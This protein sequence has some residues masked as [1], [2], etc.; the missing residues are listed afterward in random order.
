MPEKIAD[1]IAA[2]IE[3]TGRIERESEQAY[4]ALGRL[5]PLLS[6]EM[7]KSADI[8]ERS[9]ADIRSV[10]SNGSVAQGARRVDSGA[11][12]RSLHDRDSAFLGRINDSME[13]LGSLDEVIAR[14]RADSE[15]MEIISLNAMTA[16][17]KSGNEGR[18]FSVITDELKR[19]SGSTIALT[20]SVTGIGRSLLESFTRLRSGLA[21]LDAFR[22]DYFASLDETVT[23]GFGEIERDVV[24]A[25]DFFAGLLAEARR[26]SEPVTKVMRD[27]QLQDIL[28]QSLQHVAI[29]L[30]EAEDAAVSDGDSGFVAAVIDLSRE[31]LD[32][33]S[34]KLGSGAESFNRDMESV[35]SI[36]DSCESRRAEYLAGAI[37]ASC[38]DTNRLSEGSSRYLSLKRGVIVAARRLSDQVR[39]LDKSFKGISALLSRFQT[40]V[41][42][43]R[44]EVAKTSS[45]QN[46]ATTVRG[47]IELTDR[48]ESDV[49]G[50]LGMTKEFIKVAIGA[51]AGYSAEDEASAE[52]LAAALGKIESDADGFVRACNSVEVQIGAF[53]LY[54]PDFIRHL[55]EVRHELAGI[56]ELASLLGSIRADLAG[57]L[58]ELNYESG[59]AISGEHGERLRRMV[60]RFTIFTHKK[61][62][63]AIGKFAV[64][65]GSDAGEITL[66]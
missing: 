16:A 54:T 45:L 33:V 7:A 5:F 23:R 41:V 1:R 47:M 31:L 65:A 13:R 26:V 21:E 4:L 20:D 61:A 8:A 22:S 11:F 3:S 44:I 60:E 50:A 17:L 12:F 19:L 53:T 34:D 35:R 46:V 36:V 18:A 24:A 63:G 14:V 27:I 64:E 49:G 39:L 9:L 29:S 48:I 59:A 66:F 37:R 2:L 38:V 10:L 42:A 62:A 57:L 58:G 43:S 15:E 55:G 56:G 32:D 52:S 40:I 28:R 25:A 6:S 30:R 51:I